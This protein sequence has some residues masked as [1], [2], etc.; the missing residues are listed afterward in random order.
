MKKK[1]SVSDGE[2]VVKE[3]GRFTN[4]AVPRFDGVEC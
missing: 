2:N 4:T 1:R 3:M